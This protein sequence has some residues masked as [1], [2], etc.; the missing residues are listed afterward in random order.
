MFQSM[1]KDSLA[2][3]SAKTNNIQASFSVGADIEQLP[4]TTDHLG[5]GSSYDEATIPNY[6]ASHQMLTPVDFVQPINDFI[7]SSDVVLYP[8]FYP[9]SFDQIID[10]GQEQATDAIT[11]LVDG[12]NSGIDWA[13]GVA[14]D[15]VG[16]ANDCLLYTSPSPRDL[17]TSRMPS[18]A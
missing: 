9:T 2:S 14:S 15:P 13:Q 12:V 3:L 6:M 7:A 16:T 1:M 8:N 17:S 5:S 10:Y 18:S 4:S 11:G